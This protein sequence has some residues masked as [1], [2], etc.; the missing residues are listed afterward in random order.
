MVGLL[1][2]N[3]KIPVKWRLPSFTV[4]VLL[5]KD[6]R[7]DW[8]TEQV[9]DNKQGLLIN[10]CLSLQGIDLGQCLIKRAVNNLQAEF[11][12]IRQF[13][14]LSPIPGFRSWLLHQLREADRGRENVLSTYTGVD[15]YQLVSSD[16]ENPWR[17]LRQ[18]LA[19]YGWVKEE[20]K[21]QQ[22]EGILTRL[23][24]HY[25][26]NEKRRG[27]ALDSVGERGYLIH[28]EKPVFG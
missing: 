2:A 22:L 9:S 26:F 11:P 16:G 28:S 15:F 24:V 13:S 17:Q 23:C 6:W 7:Y 20:A 5:R 21:V 10:G 3:V 4:S 8:C 12:S 14:T 18:L 27:F 25:L 1:I 19:D